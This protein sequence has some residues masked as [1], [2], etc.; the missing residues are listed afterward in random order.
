MAEEYRHP[1][2][3]DLDRTDE[4][5]I[6]KD[7]VFDFDVEDDAVPLDR[8]AMLQGP[9]LHAAAG[10]PNFARP[11]GVDLPSLARACARWRSAS[12][13]KTPNTRR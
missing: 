13:A 2:E 8:T 11:S 10:M 5:P 9:P 1:P 4:L 7:V 3:T 12:P 6:L